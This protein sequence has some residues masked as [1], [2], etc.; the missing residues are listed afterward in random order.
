MNAK[1][2]EFENIS[3]IRRSRQAELAEDRCRQDGEDEE[4][5]PLE[6][7]DEMVERI[8]EQTRRLS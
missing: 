3:E 7:Y 5:I 1:I 2:R 8:N 4:L 6:S